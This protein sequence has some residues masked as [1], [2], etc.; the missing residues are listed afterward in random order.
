MIKWLKI[1]TILKMI[2]RA[3]YLRG[4]LDPTQVMDLNN[5]IDQLYSELEMERAEK[6]Q[7]IVLQHGKH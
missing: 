2:I 6:W 5:Q 4:V 1:Y 7:E 3:L